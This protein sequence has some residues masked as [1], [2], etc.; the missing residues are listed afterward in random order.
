M[1]QLTGITEMVIEEMRS[2]LE[3]NSVSRSEHL[4]SGQFFSSGLLLHPQSH[5]LHVPKLH[6]YNLM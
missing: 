1:K 2:E 6:T 4:V 5:P 3:L